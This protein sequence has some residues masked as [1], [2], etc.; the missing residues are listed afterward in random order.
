MEHNVIRKDKKIA[1][2]KTAYLEE[3]PILNYK[4]PSIQSLIME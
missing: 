4:E 3:T 1:E 2:V